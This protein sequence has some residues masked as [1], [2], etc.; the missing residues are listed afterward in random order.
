MT[1]TQFVKKEDEQTILTGYS[2]LVLYMNRLLDFKNE[3]GEK[4][5]EDAVALHKNAL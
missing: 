3:A 1:F 5:L 2:S 4:S